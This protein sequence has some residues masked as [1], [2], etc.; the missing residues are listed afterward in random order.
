ML[1][2]ISYSIGLDE[3][4]KVVREFLQGDIQRDISIDVVHKLEDSVA[5]LEDGKENIGKTVQSIEEI[6][7]LLMKVDM[8]L[9]DCSNILK[10]YQK[11]VLNFEE[12]KEPKESEGSDY[13]TDLSDI[14]A[15]LSRLRE[16]LS[17]GS[18]E[19]EGG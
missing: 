8:R 3:V 1:V 9:S 12:P 19:D 6:R 11:E 17:D 4:P 13:Q 5:Y 18:I 7:S 16:A 10:G 15:D 14:Q 2:N